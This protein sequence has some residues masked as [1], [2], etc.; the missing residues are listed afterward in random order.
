MMCGVCRW[1]QCG[2]IHWRMACNQQLCG[3][4][5]PYACSCMPTDTLLHGATACTAQHSMH[6]TAQ[7]S[8]VHTWRTPPWRPGRRHSGGSPGTPLRLPCRA[9]PTMVGSRIV[10]QH[11]VAQV[12]S[13]A[14]SR[15]ATRSCSLSGHAHPNAG[16]H[17]PTLSCRHSAP[18]SSALM[19]L[20]PTGQPVAGLKGAVA[21][22][23]ENLTRSASFCSFQFSP[24]T[25]WVN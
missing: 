8:T 18:T 5:L 6:S 1:W 11:A 14:H 12:S 21:K 15:Q 3:A 10:M 9:A 25:V 16:L 20:K 7:H 22:M 19:L 23:S 4:H 17:G 13:P 2:A 24:A